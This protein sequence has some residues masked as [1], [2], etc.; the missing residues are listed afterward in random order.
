MRI[1]T[2]GVTVIIAALRDYIYMVRLS[3]IAIRLSYVESIKTQ[4]RFSFRTTGLRVRFLP[5]P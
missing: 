3:I 4:Q 2:R 5:M 1:Y